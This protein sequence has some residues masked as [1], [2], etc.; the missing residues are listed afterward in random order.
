MT[1]CKTL[2]SAI[3]LACFTTLAHAQGVPVIDVAA[4]A[5]MLQQLQAA[6]QQLQQ[7]Q[8]T[9]ATFNHLTDLSSIQQLLAD[10]RIRAALPAEF[11]T[12]EQSLTGIGTPSARV[13]QDS[14]FQPQGDAYY[15]A[16]M[17]RIRNGNAG[18]KDVAQSVYDS[19]TAQREAI[20]ANLA[21][22]AQSQDIK[23][24]TDIGVMLAGQQ[25][26]TLQQIRQMQALAMLAQT[27]ASTREERDREQFLK[28]KEAAIAAFGSQQ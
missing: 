14:V 24:S 16:S 17:D 23:T 6:Q 9:H 20:T 22:L 1:T 8:Q 13:A 18:S 26:D 5:N 11:S 28:A 4:I 15:A 10:P 2:F 27:E 25:A 3:G 19:A 12:V 7:L 21:K